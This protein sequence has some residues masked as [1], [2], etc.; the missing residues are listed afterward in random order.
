MGMHFDANG[1][2]FKKAQELRENETF[3]EKLLWKKLSDNQLGVKFRRQHPIK[4]FIADFYCHKAKLI[5]EV[6]GG[7]HYEKQQKEYDE[8]RDLEL[9]AL[10]IEVLRFDNI[11]IQQNLTDVIEKIKLYLTLKLNNNFP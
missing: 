3:A 11:E 6:D 7:I 1:D 2:I 4:W 10:G 5:I 8:G 9:K